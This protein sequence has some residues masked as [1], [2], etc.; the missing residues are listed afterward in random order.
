[1]KGPNVACVDENCAV[2][3]VVNGESVFGIE[4]QLDIAGLFDVVIF[5]NI[6]SGAKGSI[7]PSAHAVGAA[8]IE[9]SLERHVLGIAIR[10]ADAYK[11]PEHEPVVVAEVEMLAYVETAS[12]ILGISDAEDLMVAIVA[13]CDEFRL[14]EQRKQVAARLEIRP[15]VKETTFFVES[16]CAVSQR[17]ACSQKQ[18]ARILRLFALTCFGIEVILEIGVDIGDFH[19]VEIERRKSLPQSIVAFPVVTERCRGDVA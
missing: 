19:A 7:E 4:F 10:N 5:G 13:F 3:N 14:V 16:L 6:T 8:S 12:D 15:N 18:M 1:M 17:I 9:T 11:L 2:D